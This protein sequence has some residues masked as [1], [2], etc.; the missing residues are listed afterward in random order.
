MAEEKKPKID[1]KTRLQKMGGA[2]PMPTGP[3]GGP[4][5]MPGSSSRPGAI[6]PPAI[7]PPVG[8]YSNAPPALDPNHPLAA[9]VK[10]F[11]AAP[12]PTRAAE[13]QR[14]EVDEAAVHHA[15]SGVRKQMLAI[16]GFACIVFAV[17]GWVGGGASAKGAGRD[18]AKVHAKEL[19]TDVNKA[20]DSL[21]QLA[22]KLEAGRATLMGK[23]YPDTLSKDLAAIN[24]DFDGDK[25]GGRRFDGFGKETTK[26]LIDFVTS[27]QAVND[28]KKFVM[29][30]LTKLQKPITEELKAAEAGSVTYAWVAVVDRDR[31]GEGVYLA[32]L[33]PAF[34]P[35]KE[36]PNLPEKLSFLNPRTG[37]GNVEMPHYVGGDVKEKAPIAMHV[38]PAS[39]E[40]ACPSGE[41]GQIAQLVRQLVSLK[42]DVR[43]DKTQQPAEGV[44]DEPKPDLI[45]RA[46]KLGDDL[47]KAAQ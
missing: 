13:P 9:V 14:I 25:L 39:W 8:L 18:M 46:Q 15:R 34:V 12:P 16:M 38:N 28:K 33:Q 2:A 36:K 37:N 44:I 47:G 5:P 7:P 27:V 10:P 1:L 4:L 19:Q 24:V 26:E 23:K 17:I 32:P 29:G 41:K 30:L 45:D 11:S 42:D 43:R 35:T 22:D 6:P 40:R 3:S 20:K 21:A 31:A